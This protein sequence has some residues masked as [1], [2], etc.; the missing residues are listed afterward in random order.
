M[1][2]ESKLISNLK[3]IGLTENE[4]KAYIGLVALNNAS[5]REL[6]E[7]TNIPR[8]KIYEILNN[9]VTMGYA[10]IRQGSPIHYQ[11]I[12]PSEFIQKN[13]ENYTKVFKS[14]E[15]GLEDLHYVKT[16]D[17]PIW[18]LKSRWTINKKVKE[19]IQTTTSDITIISHSADILS[20][21]TEELYQIRNKVDVLIL[22]DEEK[23]YSD[24][25]IPVHK[26]ELNFH[27]ELLEYP[28]YEETVSVVFIFDRKNVLIVQ[29]KRNE[30]E[31]ILI[32][33]P[34]VEFFHRMIHF[35]FNNLTYIDRKA[36]TITI[37]LKTNKNLNPEIK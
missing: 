25:K 24:F 23:N 33:H 19:M 10:Q 36:D 26:N 17:S 11:P 14:I 32:N 16:K 15:E 20:Q 37:S 8:A 7:F 29:E 31:G 5:T 1:L 34:V 28:N 3:K 27:K 22:V 21:F 18:Y 30:L 12:E 35:L 2:E 4:S 9:L 6:H 13:K